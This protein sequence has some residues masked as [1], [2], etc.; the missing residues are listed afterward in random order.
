MANQCQ[1]LTKDGKGPQCTRQLPEGEQFCWQHQNCKTPVAAP[2][3]EEEA[4]EIVTKKAP[5][6]KTIKKKEAPQ[7][8]TIPFKP[9]TYIE[10]LP[11]ELVEELL[12]YMPLNELF[13][14]S[15]FN[16][17]LTKQFWI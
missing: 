8:K 3:A 16:K 11:R 10:L 14:L 7:P 4:E 13:L 15:I 6:K 1:C 9:E 5:T 2:E 17:Y 12:L